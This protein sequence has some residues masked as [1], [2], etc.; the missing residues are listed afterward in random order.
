MKVAGKREREIKLSV[1]SV[2]NRAAGDYDQYAIIQ[3]CVAHQFGTLLVNSS[4]IE[5]ILEIGCGT[6][7]LTEELLRIHP[8][9]QYF[10]TDIAPAMV[11]A[12]QN[13]LKQFPHLK[14]FVMDGEAVSLPPEIPQYYDLICSSLAFQWFKDL[15]E[16]L[17]ILWART[18]RLAF[19]TL[20]TGTFR[21]WDSL[22][23]QQGIPSL[24]QPFWGEADLVK[25][26]QSL[27]P[28]A[29]FFEIK[30][31]V[32][33]FDSPLDFLRALKKIG[34]QT[35]VQS[36]SAQR[37]NSSLRSLLTSYPKDEPFLITYK[38]AYCVLA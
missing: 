17:K 5:T 29:F 26:C 28:A 33:V 13:K 4:T 3:R 18:D 25:L 15:P 14:A 34:A 12:C 6:G 7:F 37:G 27:N 32:E 23:C 16:S 9:A 21:E 38:V 19:T 20:V 11:L 8:E 30:D 22:C 24:V 10:A 1:R 31:E 2:F 35:P 36:P